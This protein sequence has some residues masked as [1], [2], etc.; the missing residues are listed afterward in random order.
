MEAHQL[1]RQC[2]DRGALGLDQPEIVWAEHDEI[3]PSLRSN[4]SR[5]RSP[6]PSAGRNQRVLPV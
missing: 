4:Q 3:Q 5:N 6:L 2:N 1:E